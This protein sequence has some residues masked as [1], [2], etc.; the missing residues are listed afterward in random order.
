MLYYIWSICTC[1]VSLICILNWRPG[2][3]LHL[4]SFRNASYQHILLQRTSYKI[5][6]FITWSRGEGVEFGIVKTS[7]CTNTSKVTTINLSVKETG[8]APS[9]SILYTRCSQMEAN[10]YN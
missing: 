6:E 8:F 9:L 10:V 5:Q 3:L 7:L 2:S 4:Y 1:D